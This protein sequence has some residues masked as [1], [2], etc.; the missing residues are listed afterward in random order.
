MPSDTGL[1]LQFAFTCP[2]PLG[3]HARPASLLAEVCNGF[4]SEVTLV[5]QRNERRAN[6]KSTLSIIAADIRMGDRCSVWVSGSD[7]NAAL[8]TIRKFIDEV[9]PGCDDAVPQPPSG[10]KAMLPRAL[11]NSRANCYFGSA[12]SPG[13]GKGTVTLARSR[14]LPRSFS[15]HTEVSPS[16]ELD[17]LQRAIAAVRERIKGKIDN[18]SELGSAMLQAHMAIL[19]DVLLG[20]RI[21]E[22]VSR[23]KSAGSAIVESG[24]YFNGILRQSQNEYLRER[25]ADLNE[26]LAQIME[27]L[28]GATAQN[29]TFQDDLFEP[30][31]VVA[32]TLGPH[33]LLD[34]N[35]NWLKGIV[36]EHSGVTSHALLLARSLGIA[37]VVGVPN[38][39]VLL[40]GAS[41]AV[42]DGY[43]GLVITPVTPEVEQF[44][45]RELN[46]H[47]Q[48]QSFLV[49]G[50]SS[51]AVT[52]DNQRIEVGANASS[53]EEVKM[54][55]ENGA[56]GIGLFRSEI[57]LL[58]QKE[59]PSE[60][61][62]ASFY[63]DVVRAAKSRPV[64]FRTLDVG[65]DKK[66]PFLDLPRES[67]PFLGYR[68][69]RIYEEHRELLQMQLRAML[70]ASMHGRIQIMPPMISSLHE[71]R[72]FKREVAEAKQHLRGKNIAVAEHIAVGMMIEVPSAA[73]ILDQLCSEADFFSIG[74]N[75][76]AQYFLAVDRENFKVAPLFD[77]LHPGFIRLLKT[78]VSEIHKRGKWVGMCGDMAADRR[79]LPVL[80]GLGLD[81]LSVPPNSVPEL[82]NG[83]RGLSTIA[84]R[85]LVD[86]ISIANDAHEIA[87]LLKSA[88]PN[89]SALPLVSEDLIK[90]ESDSTTK[91][92]A[93]QELAD[94]FYIASRC[95]DRQQL[96]D[97]VWARE[98]VYSTG[99]GFGFAAPHC[100]TDAVAAN[101]IGVLKLKRAIDWGAA[102]HEPVRMV[103]LI[104][105]RVNSA[106]EHMQV[107]SEL[108]RKLMN[109]DFRERLLTFRDASA[110]RDYLCGEL[111]VQMPFESTPLM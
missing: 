45:Q 97:A 55:L 110:M 80:L 95:S 3:M 69:V 23:G 54:G 103:I 62:L 19:D 15:E 105:M 68:G 77:V 11:R 72:A 98:E 56:E 107:L 111:S 39:Y 87:A 46:V 42:V 10:K 74:T 21:E 7:E 76:L 51:S 96:E 47:S 34:L 90:L 37:A 70:R 106:N 20:Q 26:I 71:L 17:R 25:A 109:E 66:L 14:S 64:L 16:E 43:R 93:I 12:A 49:A 59:I 79:N 50:A 22:Q 91:D 86:R 24:A 65:G 81:E 5:N 36:V 8:N 83:V 27:Q 89:A 58:E 78:I 35:A 30:S 92:E 4:R 18:S 108:A 61:H 32:E 67:N 41:E 99:L 38:A 1:S 73:F 9:L 101:S 40:S 13:I 84:G 53:A 48:R 82:K 52:Q 2:L 100:K 94:A 29:N 63:A 6:V 44:Y 57:A 88:Q 28:Y 104:A 102:D 31:I 33:Q 75:D 60:E 85:E